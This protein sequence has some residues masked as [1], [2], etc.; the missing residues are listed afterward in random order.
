M[1]LVSEDTDVT[2]APNAEDSKGKQPTLEVT[3]ATNPAGDLK[4]EKPVD[5]KGDPTGDISS[6]K[7][8]SQVSTL[9]PYDTEKRLSTS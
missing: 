5:E 3:L 1:I 8:G 7:S 9:P 4:V 6:V 2:P